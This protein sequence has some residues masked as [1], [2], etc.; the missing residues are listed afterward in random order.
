MASQLSM[1]E[2]RFDR[3]AN[4][5]SL[6]GIDEEADTTMTA[7][8]ETTTFENVV[9]TLET[10]EKGTET[11]AMALLASLIFDVAV[12]N[13]SDMLVMLCDGEKTIGIEETGALV[14]VP[15]PEGCC[16]IEPKK[17]AASI[18]HQHNW[19]MSTIRQGVVPRIPS[20]QA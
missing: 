17:I 14:G 6:C 8:V 12:M 5:G 15:N 10:A 9:G 7:V 2:L 20:F 18:S 11:V 16:L 13:D 19:N 4:I 3:S 1:I